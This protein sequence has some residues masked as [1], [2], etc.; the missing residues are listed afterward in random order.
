CAALKAADS[1]W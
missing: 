1:H